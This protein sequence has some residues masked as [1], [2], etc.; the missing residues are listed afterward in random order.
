MV[1]PRR[2]QP[3]PQILEANTFTTSVWDGESTDNVVVYTTVSYWPSTEFGSNILALSITVFAYSTLLGWADYGD[4]TSEALGVNGVMPY[5]V[6]FFGAIA[7]LA[8]V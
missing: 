8:D 5:C 1:R 7:N 2:S 4:A 3:P 6:I